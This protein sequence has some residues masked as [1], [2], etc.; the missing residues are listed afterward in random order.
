MELRP[1]RVGPRLLS[2]RPQYSYSGAK[3]PR[4]KAGGARTNL[5][6][7]VVFYL[8]PSRCSAPLFLTRTSVIAL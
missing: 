8:V 6:Q 7:R 5:F 2:V 4:P 1:E 3:H